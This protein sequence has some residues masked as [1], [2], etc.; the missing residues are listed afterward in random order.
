MVAYEKEG[1]IIQTFDYS[2]DPTEKELTVAVASP[3]GQSVV[4]GSHDR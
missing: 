1:K 2:R 4:I 3:S